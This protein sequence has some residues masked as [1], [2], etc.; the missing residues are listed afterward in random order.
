M[1]GLMVFRTVDSPKIINITDLESLNMLVVKNIV[2]NS[3]MMPN[4]VLEWKPR[5][6]KGSTKDSG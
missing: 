6:I 5:L 3:R 4:M 2:V 1:F